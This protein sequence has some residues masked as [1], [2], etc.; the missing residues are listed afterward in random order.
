MTITIKKESVYNGI[1]VKDGE[2]KTNKRPYVARFVLEGKK[3]SKSFLQPSSMKFL[4]SKGCSEELD[5]RAYTWEV[6]EDVP[7]AIGS[8]VSYD[9]FDTEEGMFIGGEWKPMTFAE[10]KQLLVAE[11][12]NDE[13]ANAEANQ[14]KPGSGLFDNSAP[15]EAL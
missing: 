7:L 6:P 4:G 14:A 10:I 5:Q 9:R 3:V 12:A 8:C 1:P 13:A 2:V 15:L 11:A